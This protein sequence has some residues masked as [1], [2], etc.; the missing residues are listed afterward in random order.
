M[1]ARRQIHAAGILLAAMMLVEPER[2]AGQS[3]ATGRRV[4]KAGPATLH[5]TI[6]GNGE[7]IVFIPSRGRGVEDFDDLSARLVQ[8]G[9]QAI[10]PEPRGIGGSTGPLEEITYHDLASDVAAVIQ[11]L[12][13]GPV[14]VIAH[15]FG[16]R[17]ARTLASDHPGTVKQ[18][19]LLAAAGAVARSAATEATTTRF[20][21]TPLSAEDR[22]AAIRQ[23]FFAAGNDPRVWAE[24]WHFEVARAQ[25]ASDRRTPLKDWW[26]GG[27]APMLILQGTEDVIVLPENAKRLAAEFPQRVTLVEIAHAGHALLPEQPEAIAKAVLP[28]LRRAP[29]ATA[30]AEPLARLAPETVVVPSGTLRLAGLLWRP[31]GPGPFPGILFSHGAGRRVDT[32]LARDRALAIGPVFAKHGYVFLHVF[33]RGYGL[34]VGQGESMRE[35]LERE[36][37]ARGEEGRRHLQMVLLTTDHLDDVM[38]GLTFL[39]GVGRVDSSRIALVGHSLGGQ[40]S[41]LAAE[42]DKTV[43][44][45]VTF[46]AAADSWQRVGAELQERLLSAVRNSRVPIFLTHAANDYS[47]VP[48]QVMSRELGKLRRSHQLKIYPAVG[49]T[50]EDGHYAV[51]TDI[52]TWEPDVFRF[53][54]EHMRDRAGVAPQRR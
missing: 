13:R 16:T 51:Y 19:I 54:D 7:P 26:T 35:V 38:A 27:S 22:L 11:S 2:L 50:P 52:A 49:T 30:V 18:L 5:V 23:V 53:L 37:K 12:G 36:A 6:K 15:A 41:L 48:G 21:E 3:V 34:S 33:R 8:A 39:K 40:L 42:R 31:E 25:R 20:W 17:V 47:I 10:L 45:A 9:Y 32:A 46:G 28:Y 24:G 44:A 1:D 14:T 4:V 43:R 29:P